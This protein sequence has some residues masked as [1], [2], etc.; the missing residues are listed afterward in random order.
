[1]RFSGVIFCH[2][3]T[4]DPASEFA[5][6]AKSGIR[7]PW[8]NGANCESFVATLTS[9]WKV[10]NTNFQSVFNFSTILRDCTQLRGERSGDSAT[11]MAVESAKKSAAEISLPIKLARTRTSYSFPH[12]EACLSWA[13]LSNHLMQW[14][15]TPVTLC[16]IVVISA[17]MIHHVSNR[18]LLLVK[19]IWSQRTRAYYWFTIVPRETC[20][21]DFNKGKLT[22]H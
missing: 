14:A 16:A 6:R 17:A 11:G 4:V 2:R 21:N 7:A 18:Q 20:N 10:R 19:R 12:R 13:G 8:G 9:S 15:L 1:M 5:S 22:F 3:I